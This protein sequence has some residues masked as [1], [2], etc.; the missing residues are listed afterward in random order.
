MAYTKAYDNLPTHPDP[1]KNKN[2]NK[3]K[4]FDEP[5]KESVPHPDKHKKTI[6]DLIT[7]NKTTTACTSCPKTGKCRRLNWNADHSFIKVTACS[8]HPDQIKFKGH[9]TTVTITDTTVSTLGGNVGN[10][11]TARG[12]ATYSVSFQA[13]MHCLIDS[14]GAS[15]YTIYR[16]LMVF[17]TSSIPASA[18]LSAAEF[19]L[20]LTAVD[21]NYGVRDSLVMVSGAT[22]PHSP[23]VDTDFNITNYSGECGTKARGTCSASAYNDIPFSDLTKITKAGTTRFATFYSADLDNAESASAGLYGVRGIGPTDETVPATPPK[24]EI[25]YDLPVTPALRSLNKKQMVI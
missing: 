4:E 2:K 21:S 5:S 1:T 20:Y 14:D 3:L 19:Q 25:T 22:C 10:W 9:S 23:V 15:T 13:Y 8:E 24:L 16:A 6:T 17:D 7:D 11:A 18:I 12:G